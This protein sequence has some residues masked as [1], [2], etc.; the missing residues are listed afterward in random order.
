MRSDKAIKNAFRRL[1]LPMS[2]DPK[3]IAA[4]LVTAIPPDINRAWAELENDN[5]ARIQFAYSNP[6][7]AHLLTCGITLPTFREELEWILA[8]FDE[9]PPGG[10]VD[11]GAGAGVAAAIV[12]LATKRNVIACDPAWGAASSIAHVSDLVGAPV[13][14]IEATAATLPDIEFAAVAIAQSILADTGFGVENGQ[15][16]QDEERRSLVSALSKVGDALV[17]EHAT[18]M[19]NASDGSAT[20]TSFAAAMSESG[21]YPIWE[22]ASFVSGY[23]V[24]IPD[25]PA[26]E[27]PLYARP[28]LCLRFSLSGDPHNVTTRLNELLA[29]HPIGAAWDY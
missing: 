26:H 23:N 21:M 25:V 9:C 1:Q 4:A 6:T 20:W 29:E 14:G 11:I 10:I 18:N 2:D 24:L 27:R 5:D 28:K 3:N 19:Q 17:I 15:E 16:G 22:S 8:R 7:Y 13:R 12:G